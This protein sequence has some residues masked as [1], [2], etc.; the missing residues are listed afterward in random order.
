MLQEVELWKPKEEDN[1]KEEPPTSI[2]S[3]PEDQE[4]K[5]PDEQTE[6]TAQGETARLSNK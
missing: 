1:K 5:V 6:K 3:L 4:D 2:V